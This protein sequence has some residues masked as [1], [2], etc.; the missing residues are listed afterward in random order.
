MLESINLQQRTKRKAWEIERPR[1]LKRWS[2]LTQ[3]AHAGKVPILIVFEGWSTAGKGSSIGLITQPLDPRFYRVWET[4]PPNRHERPYPWMRRFWLKLPARGDIVIFDRSW[5]TRV[6]YE[7][8]EKAIPEDSWRDG[9]RDIVDFER[10]IIDDGYAVVKFWLHI[11]AEEQAARLEELT[12][13]GRARRAIRSDAE[14]EHVQYDS[15]LQAAEEMLSRT[16]ASWSR[17]N[18]V[19][20]TDRFY[21]W[22]AVLTETCAAVERSLR[23]HGLPTKRST[24]ISATSPALPLEAAADL[25]EPD[26]VLQPESDPGASDKESL[27]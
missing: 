24:P 22:H 27:D 5:Y 13:E 18:I 21:T 10:A 26:E 8:V 25:P 3:I 12:G 7:R 20:A 11:S 15:Y 16:D 4:Q 19:P 2:E 1:L 14:S 6:L 9:F 23:T 17:W